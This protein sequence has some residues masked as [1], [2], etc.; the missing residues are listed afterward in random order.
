VKKGDSSSQELVVAGQV[1]HVTHEKVPLKTL[2]LD[3]KNPRIRF[4]L[5]RAGKI[6][7]T[8]AELLT[9]I[10]EQPAFSAL[11]KTIRKAG[12]LQEP[13]LIRHDGT[14]VEGNSRTTVYNIL[15][16]GKRD[17]PRWKRIQVS[18]LPKD[19]PER[20]IALL[21]ASYHVAG[22]TKW[23]AFAKGEQIY[24]LVKEHAYSPEDV[25]DEIRTNKKEV[26]QSIAAYEYLV[27]EVIPHA[28][29]G[30]GEK[31]L[32][33]KWSHALE[34]VKSR[35]LKDLREDP[36]V[37]RT[38]AKLLVKDQI[39]GMQVRDLGKVLKSKRA[40]KVLQKTGFDD[41]HEMLK[42]ADPS[43][44]NGDLRQIKKV[45]ET[46]KKMKKEDWEIFTIDP[47]AQQILLDHAKA[48]SELLSLTKL[49]AASRRG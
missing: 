6:T 30:S 33:A 45:T 24:R 44:G 21:M 48:V 20:V 25:A 32:E 28:G 39:K 13:V 8:Q 10:R 43:I 23:P 22:K 3:P 14:V 4:Q 16:Q 5:Q 46:I 29:K 31:F 42:R 11:Q 18:R 36:K 15:H 9:F 17:D 41:A 35:K 27:N 2:K 34:F 40:T 49:K 19:V 38:F 7:P 26:E 12:G 37:R 1:V 47:K